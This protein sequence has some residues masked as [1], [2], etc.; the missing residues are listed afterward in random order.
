M[1]LPTYE[2][3]EAQVILQRV[4]NERLQGI[5][6]AARIIL[7]NFEQSEAQGYRSRDRQFAIDILRKVLEP[8]NDR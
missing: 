8:T 3:L 2:R 7:Q 4:E 1:T 5:E 6:T